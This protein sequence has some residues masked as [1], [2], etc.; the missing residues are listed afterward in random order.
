MG[1]LV[2]GNHTLGEFAG[3]LIPNYFYMYYFRF[4]V[5]IL[6]VEWL[7]VIAWDKSPPGLNCLE[8]IFVGR[9]IPCGDGARFPGII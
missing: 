6:S 7:R 8:D 2:R 9:G 4:S 5:S 3:I 1:E